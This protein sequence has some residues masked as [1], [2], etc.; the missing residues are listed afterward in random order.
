MTY[1][2]LWR[3][4]YPNAKIAIIYRDGR[5][6]VISSVKASNDRRAWHKFNMSLKKRI[7]FYSGR[8]FINHAKEWKRTAKNV[9]KIEESFRVSK[10]K[11]EDLNNSEKI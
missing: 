3:A 5:D 7:N 11:Y 2:S 9:L 8:Y 4:A 10:F 1:F 6:N